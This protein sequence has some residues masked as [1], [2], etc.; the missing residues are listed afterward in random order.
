MEAFTEAFTAVTTDITADITAEVLI[1]VTT[2]IT[3]ECYEALQ[4]ILR[5]TYKQARYIDRY[6]KQDQEQ[7]LR[8]QSIA[9]QINSNYILRITIKKRNYLVETVVLNI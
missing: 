7:G 5:W 2:E 9:Q 4:E 1:E 8:L 6:N 3:T